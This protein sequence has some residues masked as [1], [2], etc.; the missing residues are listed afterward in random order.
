MNIFKILIALIW[1]V[2]IGIYSEWKMVETI[3]LS[4]YLSVFPTNFLWLRTIL[5]AIALLMGI[6]ASVT[7]E[8]L[9][10]Y[11]NMQWR[12]LIEAITKTSFIR[13]MFISPILLWGIYHAT[14]IYPDTIHALIYSFQ[15][16]FF[17]KSILSPM[18]H[19]SEIES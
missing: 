7:V 19:N 15:N 13:A 11:K 2:G 5:L 18:S 16:G 8:I 9:S 6:Y 1:I 4:E 3:E 17:W 12:L 14:D 10:N